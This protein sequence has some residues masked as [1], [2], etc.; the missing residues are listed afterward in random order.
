MNISKQ[1]G[2][3]VGKCNGTEIKSSIKRVVYYGLV[4][5]RDMA[6]VDYKAATAA[7]PIRE[8]GEADGKTLYVAEY[9]TYAGQGTSHRAA[10]SDLLTAMRRT[11]KAQAIEQIAK[12]DRAVQ[13]KADV[14]ISPVEI[15]EANPVNSPLMKLTKADLIQIILTMQGN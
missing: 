3:W 9:E 5:G 12:A 13:K 11:N 8:I 15:K 1:A 4:S 6:G 7:L 2:V 10:V 14:V